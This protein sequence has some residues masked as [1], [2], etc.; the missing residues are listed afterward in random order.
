MSTL[1]VVR[2]RATPVLG[3]EQR[4]AP[5]RTR[6]IRGLRVEREQHLVGRDTTVERV[7]ETLEE[8][9]PADP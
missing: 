8:G 2:V 9:H 5:L 6:E 1:F 4:E 3:E 7:D